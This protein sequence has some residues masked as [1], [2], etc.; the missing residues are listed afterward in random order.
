[1]AYHFANY[2]RGI[3]PSISDL[4]MEGFLLSVINPEAVTSSSEFSATALRSLCP[5]LS[6]AFAKNYA[7]G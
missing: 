4:D 3:K 2:H 6:I 7:A 1:M 5:S